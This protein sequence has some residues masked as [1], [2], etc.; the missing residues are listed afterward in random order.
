MLPYL[1]QKS[2]KCVWKVP[3]Y[4]TVSLV[5][6]LI[7]FF[8]LMHFTSIWSLDES[9]FY[10]TVMDVHVGD[11]EPKYCCANTILGQIAK[12]GGNDWNSLKW[13]QRKATPLIPRVSN[14]LLTAIAHTTNSLMNVETS[15]C[16]ALEKISLKKPKKWSGINFL[17]NNNCNQLHV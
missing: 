9:D 15:R 1:L 17:I 2:F 10:Q 7:G 4:K 6:A 3:V 12:A 16:I 5:V 11:R 13:F 14:V 8:C